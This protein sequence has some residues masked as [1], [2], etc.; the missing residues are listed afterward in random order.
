M[1]NI[2]L[3]SPVVEKQRG[4]GDFS[5]CGVTVA[6]VLWEPSTRAELGAGLVQY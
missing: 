3:E 2:K 1:I 5:G 4:S 6:R